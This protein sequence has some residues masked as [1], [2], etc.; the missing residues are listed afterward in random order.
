[1][2]VRYTDEA[3]QQIDD[4]EYTIETRVRK[5]AKRL[6]LWPDVSGVERLHYDW[7]GHSKIRTGDYRVIFT[8]EG[9]V[10]WIVYIMHRSE[11]YEV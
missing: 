2:E 10:I 11:D 7:A 6:E 8:V 9:D 4:I 5:V 1:M 3:R